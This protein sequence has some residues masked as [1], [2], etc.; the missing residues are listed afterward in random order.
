MPSGV[1]SFFAIAPLQPTQKKGEL[2]P[3]RNLDLEL[4]ANP[5]AALPTLKLNVATG[6]RARN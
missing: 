2:T 6:N 1:G 4:T 3:P 5:A